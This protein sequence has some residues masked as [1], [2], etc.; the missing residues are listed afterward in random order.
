[1]K[2]VWI[3]KFR[4]YEYWPMWAFYLPL[5]PLIFVFGLIQRHFFFF[6]NVNPGI[7][8]FGG[9]FFDSKHRIDQKIS[10]V[11]RPKSFLVRPFDAPENLEAFITNLALNFPIIIKPD[12]G[13]RGKGVTKIFSKIELKAALSKIAT[14]YLVQEFIPHLLEYGVFVSY[15]PNENKYKV[16]SLTEKQF[17]TVI[18]DG[19]SNI[20][21]LVK[22]QTRGL[23][24]YKQIIERALYSLNYVPKID[25]VCVIHTMG[26]HCNGTE[27]INKNDLISDALNNA[28]NQLMR[29]MTGIFYGRFDI[30]VASF[31]D[32]INLMDIKIL[33]FNG[34]TAEP[35]HIYDN[36]HGYFKSL[37]SFVNS[38]KYLYKISKY[39]KSKGIAP[40]K[41]VEMLRKLRARLL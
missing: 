26:N 6:T 22:S 31:D 19:K 32:L 2:K 25:E 4:N 27:F 40:I 41:H 24:F 3:I 28:M 21:E 39:N 15:L 37:L 38:W 16:I 23:V 1:M 34:I 12:A 9:F 18:G 8:A 13:E 7:D 36:S 5:L 30:K 33:E 14:D 35:I 10:S 17:F 11:Y 29:G 20:D